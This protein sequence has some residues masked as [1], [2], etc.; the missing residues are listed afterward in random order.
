[1]QQQAEPLPVTLQLPY[2][3]FL[4][5]RIEGQSGPKESMEGNMHTLKDCFVATKSVS[6]QATT[7]ANAGSNQDLKPICKLV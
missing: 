4:K 7:R 5:S 1:M 2:W 6:S 3:G